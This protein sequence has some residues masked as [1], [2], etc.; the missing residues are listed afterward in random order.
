[1]STEFIIPDCLICIYRY[2]CPCGYSNCNAACL[3]IFEPLNMS[4]LNYYNRT[5]TDEGEE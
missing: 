1:M 2:G 4:E 3:T 5:K